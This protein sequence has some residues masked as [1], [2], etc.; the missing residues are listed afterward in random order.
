MTTQSKREQFAW[1]AIHKQLDIAGHPHNVIENDQWWFS[2][3]TM[4][5]AQ[6]EEWKQWFLAEC[7]RRF[8]WNKKISERE[9][10]WFNLQ[11][12]LKIQE[13]QTHDEL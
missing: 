6:C 12:G 2:N 10:Q 8:R 4:T 1:D 5:E 9:F 7:K 3:N 13:T 11:Y